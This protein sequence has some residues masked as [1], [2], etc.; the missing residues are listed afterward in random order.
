M[1]LVGFFLEDDSEF[2]TCTHGMGACCVRCGSGVRGI[3]LFR[4]PPSPLA[5]RCLHRQSRTLR[6]PCTFVCVNQTH[7]LRTQQLFVTEKLRGWMDMPVDNRR[8]SCVCQ[9]ADMNDHSL[10]GGG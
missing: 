1:I 8:K 7:A 3:C 9:C 4:P 10:R 2:D 5:L 6:L